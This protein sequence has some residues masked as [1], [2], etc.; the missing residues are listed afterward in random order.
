VI[1]VLRHQDM[2]QQAGGGGAPWDRF[3]RQRRLDRLDRVAVAFATAAHIS[4]PHDLADEQA[5]RSIIEPLGHVGADPHPP[6]AAAGATL[7]GLGEVDLRPLA[8]QR[9]RVWPP[10]VAR[11]RCHPRR[12][13][14]RF[15]H[16]RGRHGRRVVIEQSRTDGA[17]RP[18]AE[19]QPHQVVNMG[20]LLVD[21]R[22][23]LCHGGEQLTNHLLTGRQ[24]VRQWR[25]RI[26]TL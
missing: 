14:L 7:L 23:Q 2:R 17:L 6:F 16:R 9:P 19:R 8:A 24:I 5:R 26:H 12:L 10:S 11:P 3:R 21:G 22:P 13:R 1:E 20:L 25:G 15:C 18:P 4:R